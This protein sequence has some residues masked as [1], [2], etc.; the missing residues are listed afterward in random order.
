[1]QEHDQLESFT[2][3]YRHKQ[4]Q[5]FFVA[6]DFRSMV[7]FI[8]HIGL[9]D[10]LHAEIRGDVDPGEEV[11]V[12]GGFTVKSELIRDHFEGDHGH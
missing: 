9:R 5:L 8:V 4:H 1:M 12:R 10:G 11:V 7:P 2:E 6:S 3:R